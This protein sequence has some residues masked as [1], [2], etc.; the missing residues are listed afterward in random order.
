MADHNTAICIDLEEGNKVLAKGCDEGLTELKTP[1][2]SRAPE[3]L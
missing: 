1:Q 2:Y 3:E